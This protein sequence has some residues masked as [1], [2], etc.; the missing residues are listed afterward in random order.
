MTQSDSSWVEVQAEADQPA[1]DT[2]D[3]GR[4]GRGRR[5]AP[6]SRAAPKGPPS[7]ARATASGDGDGIMLTNANSLRTMACER[8][9]RS[10]ADE[11]LSR[12]AAQS[13]WPAWFVLAALACQK[14]DTIAP[15]GSTI[16]LA[17]TP[18]VIVTSGGVQAERR[19][20]SSRR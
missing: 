6:T 3:A 14:S 13:L 16:A 4:R 20:T 5:G 2:G 8:S 17:A 10:H 12:C 7:T 1:G 11:G 18:A 19:P 9:E 15:D